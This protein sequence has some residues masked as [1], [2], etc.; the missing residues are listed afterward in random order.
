M[1][2]EA[3][4]FVLAWCFF[5]LSVFLLLFWRGLGGGRLLDICVWVSFWACFVLLYFFNLCHQ[6]RYIWLSQ[7]KI[8]AVCKSLCGGETRDWSKQNFSQMLN[9]YKCS[10]ST[11]KWY[12]IDENKCAKVKPY[13]LWLEKIWVISVLERDQ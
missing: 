1:F 5:C 13:L 8:T 9:K 6:S 11:N 2:I 4:F 12:K 10:I 3:G 7:S